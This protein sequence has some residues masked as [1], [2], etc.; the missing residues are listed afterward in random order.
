[1]LRIYIGNIN[2]DDKSYCKFND[3]W[4]NGNLKQISFNDT[5]KKIIKLIDEVD[6]IGDYKFNSKFIPGTA[7]SVTELSTGC[8]TAINI[9][10]FPNKIFNIAECGNNVINVILKY[11]QGNIYTPH[12]IMSNKFNNDIEV[13]TGHG[14][15][16]PISNNLQLENLL[17]NYYNKCRKVD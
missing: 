15:T 1:M 4:F 17:K 10:A 8:K 16:Y 13:I 6:Y 3:D 2:T 9:A 11:K 7:V 12:F 14:K 5:I